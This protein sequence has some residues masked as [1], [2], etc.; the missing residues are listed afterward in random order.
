MT[1]SVQLSGRTTREAS[2]VANGNI[3]AF[4]LAVDN[5]GYVKGEENPAGFFDVVAF[6]D[7]NGRASKIV[8]SLTKGTPVYV[9]GHL[10]HRRWQNDQGEK[11]SATSVVAEQVV[12]EDLS[13]AASDNEDD[14]SDDTEA[15]GF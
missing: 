7:N 10:Q 6:D 8:N 2:L 9:A 11:R 4:T 5:A 3:A 15:I 12:I 13:N 1:N 14:A